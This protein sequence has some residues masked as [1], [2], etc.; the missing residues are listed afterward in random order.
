M[1]SI[2]AR[3]R[4]WPSSCRSTQRTGSPAAMLSGWRLGVCPPTGTAVKLYADDL[5]NTPL[6]Q[7][8]IDFENEGG[9]TYICG[10]PPYVWGNNQTSD[11]KQ[12]VFKL[13]SSERSAPTSLL[14]WRA[15]S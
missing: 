15:R 6:E 4:R 10:N 5:F 1:C 14:N 9:E 3:R 7:A 12:D 13:Q 2:A 11:Q 8:Q